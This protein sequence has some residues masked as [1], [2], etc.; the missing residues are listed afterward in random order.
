VDKT[1]RSSSTKQAALVSGQ[2]AA[3]F[4]LK[5]STGLV[6]GFVGNLNGA[7]V[8][9]SVTNGFLF[10]LTLAVSFGVLSEFR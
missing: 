3:S 10:A 4:V 5:C 8:F 2:A 6:Y 1:R 9:G 7:S